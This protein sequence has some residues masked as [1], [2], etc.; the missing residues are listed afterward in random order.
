M[1][2]T[3]SINWKYFHIFSTMENDYD[4]T[5]NEKWLMKKITKQVHKT[6]DGSML[7]S[8]EGLGM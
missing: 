5:R 4:R 6:K 8:L 2:G 7:T 1:H 3:S